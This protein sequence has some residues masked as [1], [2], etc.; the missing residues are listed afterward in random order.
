MPNH[1]AHLSQSP[2]HSAYA[3]I[4]SSMSPAFEPGPIRYLSSA[5]AG[6]VPLRMHLSL[7][8]CIR[9]LAFASIF[10]II[11]PFCSACLSTFIAAS[12]VC[13]VP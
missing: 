10:I 1:V 6:G 3:D 12:G 8:P 7:R 5:G 11:C 9:R 4:G 2:G 13:N